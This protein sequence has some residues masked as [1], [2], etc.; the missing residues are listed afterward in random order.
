MDQNRK[1][2]GTFDS[3]REATRAIDQLKDLGYSND[4]ISVVAK[5][6]DDVAGIE[7]STGTHVADG[8]A[9]GAVTGG[10]LGGIG[11]LL[12]G[13]GLL[14][15]PGVGPLLAAGPIAATLSGAALGAGAGGLVGALI[16]LGVPEDEARL[17]EGSLNAGK[18]LV[19]VDADPSLRDR[20]GNIFGTHTTDTSYTADR[21]SDTVYNTTEA[22]PRVTNTVDLD[23]DTTTSYNTSSSMDNDLDD[24]A[25]RL[26][27]ERLNV[28]KTRVQTGE[29][30]L[31]K[32]VVQEQQTINVPVTHEEVYIERRAV[33]DGS[34]DN[35]PIGDNEVIRVPLTEERVNVTKTPVVTGEV[36][37]GK[38]EVQET[39]QISETVRREEVRLDQNGNPIVHSD[40]TIDERNSRL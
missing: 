24:H 31:R 7:E 22:S 12:V 11:G 9:T 17:H 8:A 18:I 39:E 36:S 15:I 35:T 19:I 28:D 13:L 16:G 10:A 40:E 3:E 30:E 25:L 32:E 14:A 1:L 27:E 5:N 26:R 33:T 29:V 21:M 6:K 23:R 38:R 4:Q 37:I 34:I 2:V 20:V